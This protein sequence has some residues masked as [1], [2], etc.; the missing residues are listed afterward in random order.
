MLG[1]PG[2]ITRRA[3]V[4]G[5]VG[6]A[7]ETRE[8]DGRHDPALYE[9]REHQ[10]IIR[11]VVGDDE[12]A[13]QARPVEISGM[14]NPCKCVCDDRDEVNVHA[15]IAQVVVG[16]ERRYVAALCVEGFKINRGEHAP[17]FP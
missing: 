11:K 3:Q 14:A 13:I 10:T 17:P 7:A 9:M 1:G 8:L 16:T 6:R 5:Q 12:R 15:R 4:D 2:E